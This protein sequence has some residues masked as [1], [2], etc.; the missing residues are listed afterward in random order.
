MVG[1]GGR[2]AAVLGDPAAARARAGA[3]AAGGC[4]CRLR[5]DRVG[6]LSRLR[7]QVA[8][9]RLDR[10]AKGRGG[11]DRGTPAAVGGDRRRRQRR[12]RRRA[13]FA[14]DLRWPATSIGGGGQRR[15]RPRCALRR[16]WLAG[17]RRAERR[18]W[19]RF[20]CAT[21]SAG[22]RSAG[23]EPGSSAGGGVARGVDDRGDLV[24]ETD[25]RR[26]RD[27]RLGRGQPA[28]VTRRLKD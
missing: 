19:R 15:R 21:R 28:L 14:D 16:R 6:E 4:G 26:A 18:P 13:S 10:R 24:V 9:R 12:D 1:A 2:G 27:A 20:A 5:G 3:V 11:A 17:R 25:R 23:R 8:Q 7:D 22:A